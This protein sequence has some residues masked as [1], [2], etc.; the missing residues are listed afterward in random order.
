VE[1]SA[2]EYRS[3]RP[4]EPALAAGAV[5]VDPT[6]M[7]VLLLHHREQNRWCFPKGHVDENET[8]RAAA[9]R[10]IE[11][12]AGLHDLEILD[13][14]GEAHYRFYDDDREK[15]E[16]KTAVYLLALS[17]ERRAR[18]EPTF[19]DY[20]W[21]SFSEARGLLAYDSERAVLEGARDRLGS[22][23]VRRPS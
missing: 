22:G 13:E 18:L 14:I 9:V 7:A 1:S 4:A 8:L 12:E 15:N 16:F 10:E 19:D 17:R 3:D 20:R 5:V 11:E 21:V 23:T 2:K 6:D